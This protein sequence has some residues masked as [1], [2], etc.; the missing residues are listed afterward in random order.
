MQVNQAFLP[1]RS[2]GFDSSSNVFVRVGSN[3]TEC[4]YFYHQK[5]YHF[6]FGLFFF[7]L[8]GYH[9]IWKRI[10]Q[11]LVNLSWSFSL[12]TSKKLHH[13]KESQI[14]NGKQQAA[15]NICFSLQTILIVYSVLLKKNLGN[16]CIWSWY[17]VLTKCTD[18]LVCTLSYKYTSINHVITAYWWR[19]PSLSEWRWWLHFQWWQW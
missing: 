7:I 10:M 19:G 5:L 4:K 2:K 8:I 15:C 16:L 13:Q 11:W 12:S 3:P 14:F 6:F 1:E 9:N 17:D 18:S